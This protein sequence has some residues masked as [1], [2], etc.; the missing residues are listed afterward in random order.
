[1]GRTRP[2]GSVATW[3]VRPSARSAFFWG[4]RRT[5]S[6]VADGPL[7]CFGLSK[8]GFDELSRENPTLATLFLKNVAGILAE[9]LSVTTDQIRAF[10][11][12]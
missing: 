3:P 9:R 2:T 6:I 4:R 11:A 7:Q 1:M 8:A 12:S 5:A 10:E